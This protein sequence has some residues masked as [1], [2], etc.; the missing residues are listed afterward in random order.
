MPSAGGESGAGVPGAVAIVFAFGAQEKAVQSLVLPHR[1][2]AIEPAGKHFVDVTLMADV[3][4]KFVLGRIED[5]MQRNGQFDDAEIRPEMSAGLRKNLDE[6]FAHFLRELRQ[7][8]FAQRFDVR[9]R[10]D[11]IEQSRSGLR[12]SQKSLT[13][14][15]SFLFLLNRTRGAFSDAGSKSFH[16]RLCRHCCG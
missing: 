10:T 14:S 1:A 12:L 8:L 16:R 9:G 6:R 7:V 15:F 13:S 3:E 2:D 11:A 5:A 4:D